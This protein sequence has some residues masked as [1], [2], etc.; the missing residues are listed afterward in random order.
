MLSGKDVSGVEVTWQRLTESDGE[1][2]M[3]RLDKWQLG[4]LGNQNQSFHPVFFK[5]FYEKLR[6][7]ACVCVLRSNS[8]LSKCIESCAFAELHEIRFNLLSPPVLFI[9]HNEAL[10]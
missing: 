8:R 1:G 2:V 9:R 4:R 7:E 10:I 6:W 5:A 3:R